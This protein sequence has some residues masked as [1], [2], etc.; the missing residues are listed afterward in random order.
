MKQSSA[1]PERRVES[2]HNRTFRLEQASRRSLGPFSPSGKILRRPEMSRMNP[3]ADMRRS[4]ERIVDIRRPDYTPRC[5][6]NSTRLDLSPLTS[7]Q[8]AFLFHFGQTGA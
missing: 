8:R 5:P 2:G 3:P 6:S 1:K 7:Y 4:G